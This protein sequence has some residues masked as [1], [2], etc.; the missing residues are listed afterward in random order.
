MHAYH[1]PGMVVL[2]IVVAIL[3]SYTALDLAGRVAVARGRARIAWLGSGAV[4]LGTGIWA[5]HFVAMLAFHLPVPITYDIPLVVGSALAAFVASFLA[6]FIASRRTLTAGPLCLVGVCMGAGI[7]V[8]HYTGMAAIRTAATLYYHANLVAASIAI[9]IV[10]S[11][12]ALW[13]AFRLRSDD[14]RRGHLLRAGAAIVM[15]FAITGMHYT[16]MAA[17]YFVALSEPHAQ[18]AAG[19]LATTGLGTAVVC[20][21]FVVLFLALLSATFDRAMERKNV[22]LERLAWIVDSSDDA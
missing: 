2:S 14:S 9:A 8:M 19:V 13:L 6:L 12:A 15:G 1:H 20:S 16:A 18:A 4:A 17:A 7:S 5:M 11:M 22:E 3:A 10:A 21:T